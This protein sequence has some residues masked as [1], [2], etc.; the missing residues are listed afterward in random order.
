[1]APSNM[2]KFFGGVSGPQDQVTPKA[3]S[4]SQTNPFD[5]LPSSVVAPTPLAAQRSTSFASLAALLPSGA[6]TPTH[7]RDSTSTA[8]GVQASSGVM[9][10][11]GGG[12]AQQ[13]QSFFGRDSGP[14]DVTPGGPATLGA[15]PFTLGGVPTTG[16]S[17]CFPFTSCGS[18]PPLPDQAPTETRGNRRAILHIPIERTRTIRD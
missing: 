18:I 12:G 5:L 17:S 2:L 16:E 10:S 11:P 8:A 7:K 4:Q 13:Q 14:G 6:R 3:S 1:M 15:A 9:A